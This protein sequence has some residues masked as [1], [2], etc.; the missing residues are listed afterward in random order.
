MLVAWWGW[1]IV[2]WAAFAI[3]S[4][5]FA[6]VMDLGRAIQKVR[7]RQPDAAMVDD[8]LVGDL[9]AQLPAPEPEATQQGQPLRNPGTSSPVA[10]PPRV[11]R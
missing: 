10:R 6:I 2:G 5:L 4:F 9:I 3:F 7:P 8:S 1:P 11:A